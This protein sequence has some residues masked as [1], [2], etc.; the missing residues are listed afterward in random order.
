MR[1][2]RKTGNN[3][4]IRERQSNGYEV[5]VVRTIYVWK[6]YVISSL[7]WNRE[8]LRQLE[9]ARW[10]WVWYGEPGRWERVWYGEPGRW[11]RVWYGEPGKDE[12]CETEGVIMIRF[13]EWWRKLFLS[14]HITP[15]LNQLPVVTLRVADTDGRRRVKN[16]F[17]TYW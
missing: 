6:T 5:F 4:E 13:T 16:E 12:T 11:E 14:L 17:S 2:R 15:S 9:R 10:E 7:E 8:G 1:S 3:Q